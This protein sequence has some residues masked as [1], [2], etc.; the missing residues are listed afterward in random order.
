[1]ERW[2]RLERAFP[3]VEIITFGIV[4]EI[5]KEAHEHGKTKHKHQ[6]EV[7]ITVLTPIQ[8]LQT[9]HD[10]IEKWAV[11]LL[12]P[13][14]VIDKFGQ[15]HADS[16]LIHVGLHRNVRRSEE[17]TSELQSRQYLVCRLLLEKKNSH[18]A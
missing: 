5:G 9:A 7:G 15:E 14:G 10:I 11:V 12:S 3:K 6:M 1:M 18:Q 17:H 8:P 4:V 13:R 16:Y 2:Q